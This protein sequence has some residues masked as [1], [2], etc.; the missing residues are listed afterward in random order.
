MTGST[1]FVLF[2]WEM[3]RTDH[4]STAA[5]TEVAGPINWVPPPSARTLRIDDSVQVEGWRRHRCLAQHHV[6]LPSMV[7][8]VIEQMTAATCAVST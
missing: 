7:D 3:V 2:A 8:L 4:F 5:G 6:H 1:L